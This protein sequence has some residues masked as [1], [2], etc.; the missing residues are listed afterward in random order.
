MMIS[1]NH[2]WVKNK[3]LTSRILQQVLFLESKEYPKVQPS[4]GLGISDLKHCLF[5]KQGWFL[6]Y[7]E[8]KMFET[9]IFVVLIRSS[10]CTLWK[11]R[12]DTFER[13][14]NLLQVEIRKED[15]WSQD[16][17]C[18]KWIRLTLTNN[19][20]AVNIIIQA[21]AQ[22]K[23]QQTTT[24]NTTQHQ[25]QHRFST[26]HV[27]WGLVA[28]KFPWIGF[29]PEWWQ[30]CFWAQ[31]QC[32]RRARQTEP[33]E[34]YTADK[35]HGCWIVWPPNARAWDAKQWLQPFE[36]LIDSGWFHHINV[37][38]DFLGVMFSDVRVICRCS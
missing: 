27:F 20:C 28:K 8:S 13:G 29:A 33:A 17:A 2:K 1:R 36:Q 35:A 21:V 15:S 26:A 12:S 11:L 34:G 10:L 18:T 23:Y 38:I 25:H 22:T 5:W 9:Y 30:K 16:T 6:F 37:D 31:L 14:C 3:P 7:F 24:S 32:A 19:K 4:K